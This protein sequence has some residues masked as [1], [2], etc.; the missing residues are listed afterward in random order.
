MPNLNK[1]LIAGHLGRDAE[2]TTTA[3]GYPIGRCSV[4]VSM[5]V[6]KDGEWTDRA[7]WFR[8]VLLGDRYTKI[9]ERLT[10]GTAVFVEGRLETRSWEDK[11]GQKRY[12]TEVIADHLS[13]LGA[14]AGSG[15][16]PPARE[17]LP[18]SE[19][20]DEDTPF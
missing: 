7:E 14:A 16:R 5:R 15:S 11:D 19:P 9:R 17:A 6:K 3:G 2:F 10:K 20:D 13:L 18:S 12:L 4:A 1:C 8:V